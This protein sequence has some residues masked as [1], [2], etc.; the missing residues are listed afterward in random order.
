M[1][2][3]CIT[4]PKW[5]KRRTEKVHWLYQNGTS[6]GENPGLHMP[7]WYKKRGLLVPEW[8][9]QMNENVRK[10][11]AEDTAA[12]SA[13][14]AP[15][16]KRAFVFAEQGFVTSKLHAE[17]KT[18]CIL[19][20][21]SI[22]AAFC[23]SYIFQRANGMLD[24][25]AVFFLNKD[26]VSAESASPTDLAS[27][28]PFLSADSFFRASMIHGKYSLKSFSISLVQSTVLKSISLL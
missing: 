26:L 12:F 6:K 8:D 18:A 25:T 5:H 2:I 21:S 20:G 13:A 4:V 15:A 28:F 17:I 19:D 11:G 3:C 7:E 9:S 22:Q 10:K 14:P 16:G 24:Y 27:S 1:A 23:K